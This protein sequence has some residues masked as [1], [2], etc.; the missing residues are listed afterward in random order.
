MFLPSYDI[1]KG[2]ASFASTTYWWCV[3]WTIYNIFL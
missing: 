2:V 3:L 1:Q